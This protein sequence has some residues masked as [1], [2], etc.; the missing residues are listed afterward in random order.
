[1]TKANTA[2][3]K[4]GSKM[5]LSYKNRTKG[6]ASNIKYFTQKEI[7]ALLSVLSRSTMEKGQDPLKLT[8]RRV[9]D[10]TLF[11]LG[12]DLG[13]RVSEVDGLHWEQV[14]FE[15]KVINIYDEK[16]DVWRVCT[17][18]QPTWALLKT[19]SEMVDKRIEKKVFPF[20]YKTMNR[21]IKEWADLAG[22]KRI[23]EDGKN[24]V[25]WHMLRHTHVV[26]AR[27]AGRDWDVIAQQTGDKVATL[28]QEYSKLS[29]EDRQKVQ[30]E[31]PIF[32]EE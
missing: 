22:V 16:K 8:A 9:Q 6:I 26:Q 7:H 13:A 3:R 15:K 21:R 29:I 25:V 14:D 28:I 5:S 11:I 4:K 17:I 31:N 24:K 18:S 12:L 23:D 19:Y 27:R 10:K 1:M 30:D 32:K 2:K 20:G